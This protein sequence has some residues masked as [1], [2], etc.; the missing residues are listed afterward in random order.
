MKLLFKLT[1]AFTALLSSKSVLAE[2]TFNMTKGVTDISNDIWGLH[3]MVFW[4]CVG[5]G[6]VVFGAMFYSIIAHRK[7]KGA[8]ASNFHE[9]TT[10]EF[11]WT[12]I[13]VLILIAMAIPAS[14]TLIDI[15]VLDKADM[16]IKVTGVRWKWQYDYPEEGISFASNLAQSSMDVIKGTPEERE[17]VHKDGGYLREVDKRLVV[18]VDTTIRFLITSNDV[19]H[20]WWVPAFGLKQDA[21]PGFI[22][23]AW[24]KPNII[25][26]Y[27]GQCA[28]LCGK[29]A[30]KF[31]Q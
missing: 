31:K 21:N 26:T 7:S 4:V 5:I 23:D 25:G 10:V 18:P 11:L 3:M 22:N 6:V 28:E 27:R 1:G 17:A 30:G 14:K 2:Y 12:G 24:A 29:G 20:N 19:I 15:E 9:S 8:K 16:T 13:P